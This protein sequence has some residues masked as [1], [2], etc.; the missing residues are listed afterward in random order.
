MAKKKNSKSIDIEISLDDVSADFSGTY[1]LDKSKLKDKVYYPCGFRNVDVIIGTNIYDNNDKLLK[2]NRGFGSGTWNTI[3]G[4]SGIGKTTVGIQFGA[5][6]VKPL[7]DLGAKLFVLDVEG[8]FTTD[9]IKSLAN[10][11][12]HQTRCVTIVED[13]PYIESV[14]E[15]ITSIIEFKEKNKLKYKTKNAYNDDIEIYVPTVIVIDSLT[16][17]PSQTV[18]EEEKQ[19]PTDALHQ[20]GAIDKLFKLYRRKMI[21]YNIIVFSICAITEE[22]NMTNPMA[23]P[24]K[25]WKGLPANVKI[26]G[27]RKNAYNSDI[28]ILLDSYEEATKDKLDTKVSFLDSNYSISC[29]LFKS[30]QGLDA[31]EFNLV[32]SL[33]NEFNALASFI[34]ECQALKIIESAGSVKKIQGL[35]NNVKTQDL[36]DKF[37]EDVDVRNAL[38]KAYDEYR[39]NT[40]DS[41]RKTQEQRDKIDKEQELLM[42]G[43]E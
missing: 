22:I 41:T 36:I 16:Q 18:Y 27:G 14:G 23:R 37:K 20:A 25:R 7:I 31:L 29:I 34:Y 35:D 39:K 9:R 17:M 19:N 30:R 38:F 10:F 4:P 1:N 33:Q 15:L 32:A 8:G 2:A 3:A 26:L 21:E 43:F 24:K 11:S 5:N 28:G 40:L 13:T 6:I 12:E 42:E